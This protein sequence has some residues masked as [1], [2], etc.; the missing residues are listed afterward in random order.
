VKFGAKT[1]DIFGEFNRCLLAQLSNHA[2]DCP[3]YTR[4]RT[5]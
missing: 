2:I 3:T 4:Y 5:M 1:D